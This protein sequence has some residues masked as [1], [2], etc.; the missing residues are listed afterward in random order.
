MYLEDLVA[1]LVRHDTLAARQWI[2]DL[3]RERFDWP[4]VPAPS[5]SDPIA[6]AVAAGVAELLA[7]RAGQE[8]PEWT[9]AVPAL[10]E[11]FFL[12]QAAARMPRLRRSCE[13][14][15]P[16]PLR[17]RRLLAPPEFLTVA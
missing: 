9:T 16:E 17:R 8:P 14:E 11:P 1:A 7:Q 5:N 15:G 13:E 10:L 12:V 4:S 2:I 3:G 6:L